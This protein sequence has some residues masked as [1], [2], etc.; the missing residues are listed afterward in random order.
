MRKLI[1][2][3]IGLQIRKILAKNAKNYFFG[4][5]IFVD[6]FFRRRKM[7]RWESSETRFRKVF[8]RFRPFSDL[9]LRIRIHSDTFGCFRQKKTSKKKLKKKNESFATFFDFLEGLG[10]AGGKRT[11]KSARASNFAPDTPLLRSVR[12]EIAKKLPVPGL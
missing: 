10:G 4:P 9:F 3:S 12:P 1:L 11:S 6:F 8:R 5:K 2:R 7:K